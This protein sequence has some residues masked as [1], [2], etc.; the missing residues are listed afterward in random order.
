VD[1]LREKDT[2]IEKCDVSIED[3]AGEL[4]SRF[5][6]QMICRNGLLFLPH[7]NGQY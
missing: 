3:G 5:I 4:K 1:P 6:V 7:I 2:G